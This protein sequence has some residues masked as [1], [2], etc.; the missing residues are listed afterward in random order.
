MYAARSST[1]FA[2]RFLLLIAALASATTFG[3][4]RG[5][6]RGGPPQPPPVPK[7]AAPVD[8]TGYWVAQVTT[9]WRWR[10]TTPPKGD[11][12]GVP[13][14]AEARKIAD[15]WDPAK[16]EAAGEQ[17]RSYGAPNIMRVPGRIHITW[18]DDQTLKLETDAGQ[19]T[20]MFYFGA[21]QGQGGDW[22]GVSQASWD[23][24]PGGAFLGARAM[25]PSGALKVV[26]TKFKMGYIR[27]NGVPYSA[28]ATL[29]E[30]FDV[31]KEPGGDQYL[32]LSMTLVDPTYFNTPFEMAVNFK[33]QADASGWNP[34]PCSAR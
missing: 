31:I 32:V 1:Q 20:R 27:K 34:T 8:L 21:P 4:G 18:V 28:N 16:D 23:A 14:N 24:V 12:Q 6:G 7:A 15:A 26:T 5:G 3:Q 29:T 11:Y 33:K 25:V 17:C 22:Q 30:Y 9:D 10:M 2:G 19:Q 13:L